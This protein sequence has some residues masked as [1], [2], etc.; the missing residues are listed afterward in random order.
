MI[1]F[2]SAF[3]IA[4]L[5]TAGASAQQGYDPV[6]VVNDEVITGIDLTSRVNLAVAGANQSAEARQR[7]RPLVLDGLINEALQRQEARR[8]GIAIRREAV[9]ERIGGLARGNRTDVNGFLAKVREEGALPSSVR[10]QVE[11]QLAWQAAVARR[12]AGRLNITDEDIDGVLAEYQR[13]AGSRER[14]L[15]EI[16]IPFSGG[17]NPSDVVRVAQSLVTEIRGGKRFGLLAQQFSQSPTAVDGGDMGWVREGTLDPRLEQAIAAT[18]DGQIT[19]A[20]ALE[21]GVYVFGV[22]GIRPVGQRNAGSRLSLLQLF[23]RLPDNLESPEAQ[24]K[25]ARAAA[26]VQSV[27]TCG[28]FR[29]AIQRFGE[30]GSGNM[31]EIDPKTLAPELARVLTNIEIGRPA[32][33]FPVPN[34]ASLFMV[35]GRRTVTEAIDRDAIREQLLDEEIN[36]QARRYLRDVRRQAYISIIGG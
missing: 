7:L 11:A 2:F 26:I 33:P 1:R 22:R 9:E 21:D 35:C 23:F 29:T 8:L 25:L 3:L 31:G 12:F 34:G 10:N 24:Q 18:E 14:Q 36:E 6:A 13:F 30:Q 19:D 4:V 32:P 15:S 28:Q 20:I 27:R 5:A 16:Y 17:V